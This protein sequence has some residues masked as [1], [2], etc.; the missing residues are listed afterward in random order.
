PERIEEVRYLAPL[1]RAMVVGLRRREGGQPLGQQRQRG[2]RA[3][4]EREIGRAGACPAHVHPEP[5]AE[6]LER[7]RLPIVVARAAHEADQH[8]GLRE[9]AWLTERAAWARAGLGSERDIRRQPEEPRVRRRPSS[10]CGTLHPGEHAAQDVAQDATGGLE[11]SLQRAPYATHGSRA[12]L[13]IS[14][15]CA[16]ASCTESSLSLSRIFPESATSLKSSGLPRVRAKTAWFAA[17]TTAGQISSYG[18][19]AESPECASGGS[20]ESLP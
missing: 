10:R 1:T 17:C 2:W 4:G 3:A 6:V 18:A 7:S 9:V 8:V 14:I 20:R 5:A 12:E 11:G 16:R 15:M 13:A 19:A